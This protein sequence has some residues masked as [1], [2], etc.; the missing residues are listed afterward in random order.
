M[1]D[2]ENKLIKQ[3]Q[4]KVD[5][6]NLSGELIEDLKKH[7]NNNEGNILLRFSILDRKDK[8]KLRMISSNKRIKVDEKLFTFL[9]ESKMIDAQFD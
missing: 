4:L 6:E 8:L 9:K 3:L 2:A 5:L 7:I 1:Q